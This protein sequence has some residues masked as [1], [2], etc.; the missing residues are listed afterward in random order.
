MG[1][2]GR[3]LADYLI[4][5]FFLNGHFRLKQRLTYVYFIVF[6]LVC[7]GLFIGWVPDIIKLSLIIPFLAGLIL[8]VRQ[9]FWTARAARVSRSVKR[10]E[11]LGQCYNALQELEETGGRV[12]QKQDVVFSLRYAF[13]FTSG[14]A[15]S[16]SDIMRLRIEANYSKPTYLRSMTEGNALWAKLG[17]GTWL[18]LAATRIR[19]RNDIIIRPLRN[20][21]TELIKH[22]PSIT[23]E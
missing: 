13:F 14:A 19:K 17:D 10:L 6:S 5:G 11:N 23:M 7:A 18:M 1:E 8:S 20:Y 9:L 3:R 4:S 16:Y 2:A 12:F 15:V 21:A 22:N